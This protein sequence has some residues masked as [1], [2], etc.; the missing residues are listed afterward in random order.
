MDKLVKA[1]YQD[2]LEFLQW[3]KKYFELNYNGEEY[4]A[5]TKR[6]GQD[7]YYIAGGNKVNAPNKSGIKAAAPSKP[8]SKM[9]SQTSSKGPSTVPATKKAG[10]IGGG[11]SSADV[12]KVEA[13]LAEMKL[14]MNTI[15]KERDFYFG[16]L[17]DIEMLLQQ[18]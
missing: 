10:T 17:R 8:Y 3:L 1:K 7:L 5:L 4:D 15:E 16:K 6:K 14:N 18:H 12:K 13:E 11:G 2:N 9:P